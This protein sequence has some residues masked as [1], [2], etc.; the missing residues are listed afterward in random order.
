MLAKVIGKLSDPAVTEDD[1][2]RQLVIK[3]PCDVS[4]PG[5]HSAPSISGYH[6]LSL[7]S[8][9]NEEPSLLGEVNHCLLAVLQMLAKRGG[10]DR[11]VA[12]S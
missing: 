2:G 10:D 4:R 11:K 8:I 3:R 9:R 5:L 1:M 7:L 6:L 12:P